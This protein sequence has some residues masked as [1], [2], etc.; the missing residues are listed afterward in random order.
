[1]LRCTYTFLH[2][3]YLFLSD[4]ISAVTSSVK[5]WRHD[6]KY[7]HFPVFGAIYERDSKVSIPKLFRCGVLSGYV[8]RVCTY[9]GLILDK[10]N[11]K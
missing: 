2:F 9:M 7:F 5:I 1:M 3:S 6:I 8:Y 11:H 10:H 4:M